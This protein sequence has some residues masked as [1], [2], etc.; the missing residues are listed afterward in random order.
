MHARKPA[1]HNGHGFA[2]LE[3][4]KRHPG[5]AAHEVKLPA[6]MSQP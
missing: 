2:C 1:D 5:M 6:H 4:C 3:G